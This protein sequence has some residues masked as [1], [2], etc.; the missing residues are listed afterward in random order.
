MEEM[1]VLETWSY[2]GT[3]RSEPERTSFF[4][5]PRCMVRRHGHPGQWYF[6]PLKKVKGQKNNLANLENV[7]VQVGRWVVGIS[8]SRCSGDH[9]IPKKCWQLARALPLSEILQIYIHLHTSLPEHPS[10]GSMIRFILVQVSCLNSSLILNTKKTYSFLN[11]ESTG[12]DE[13]IEVV[14]ALRRRWKSESFFEDE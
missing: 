6:K 3:Q 10:Y 14:C 8:K 5:R 13:I 11:T 1:V 12:Q 2:C 7:Q 4:L 9:M